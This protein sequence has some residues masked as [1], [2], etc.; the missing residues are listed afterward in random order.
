MTITAPAPAQTD[1]PASPKGIF[2]YYPLAMF[3]ESPLNPRKH[4]DPVK[5]AELTESVR[6]SGVLTPAVARP[7]KGGKH[8][9]AAG[10]RRLRAAKAAGLAEI[11]AIVRE[12]TDAEFLEILSV[13]NLQRDD[14]HPLEEAQGYKSLLTID[15]YDVP[16]IAK[17]VGKSESY[18]YDR[19]KLLQLIK[20]A[21]KLFLDQA[22][23]AGHAILIARLS[24]A[25]QERLVNLDNGELWESDHGHDPLGVQEEIGIEHEP[26]ERSTPISVRALQ[27]WIDD[28]IRFTAPD[29]STP[30]LF[31]DTAANLAAAEAAKQKVIHISRDHMLKEDARDPDGGRTYSVAS[32]TRADGQPERDW[33]GKEI[34]SKTCDRSVLGLVVAGEGRGESFQVCIDK[35]RCT[36]H[37]KKEIDER[38]RREREKA[39]A[40]KSASAKSSGEPKEPT[41]KELAKQ[42]ANDLRADAEHHARQ[43]ARPLVLEAIAKAVRTAP[44]GSDSPIAKFIWD[45]LLIDGRYG[46]TDRS[47]EAAKLGV[48]KGPGAA[49][50]LRH[51]V[52]C[53]IL[54]ATEDNYAWENEIQGVLDTLKLGVKIEKVEKPFVEAAIAVVDTKLEAEAK[55]AKKPDPEKKLAAKQKAKAGKR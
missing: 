37:Y 16:K 55:A 32:W 39:K 22:F 25:D 42:R 53:D 18:V 2:G 24:K 9:L 7:V 45:E 29:P 48:S 49:D 46:L 10:H 40:P 19:I 3:V 35:K 13:E 33:S 6:A 36:V 20:P 43:K 4:F 14:V 47:K 38:N 52:M 5:L 50:F 27:T 34:P 51:V 17:R 23:T 8:E 54:T 30:H 44:T 31:D 28:H 12:M 11:P 1:A 15:G 26:G 21:Q 41:E